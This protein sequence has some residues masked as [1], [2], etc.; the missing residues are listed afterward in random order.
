MTAM[1]EGNAEEG[2][3]ESP[4]GMVSCKCEVH[5]VLWGPV[6]SLFCYLVKFHSW[7]PRFSVNQQ[8]WFNHSGD[9]Q[10]SAQPLLIWVRS[11][12]T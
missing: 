1:I 12:S 3:T 10:V 2:N 7:L 11:C 6:K 8:I 4:P 9:Q 5:K